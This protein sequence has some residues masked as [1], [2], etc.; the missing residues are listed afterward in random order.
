MAD[1]RPTEQSLPGE[2]LMLRLT[3]ETDR[4]AQDLAD[5][6]RPMIGSAAALELRAVVEQA[7]DAAAN[8]V[9]GGW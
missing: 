8:E 2:L 1:Q 4:V 9:M 5:L 7:L 6:L 3:G